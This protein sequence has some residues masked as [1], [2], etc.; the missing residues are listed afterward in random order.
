MTTPLTTLGAAYRYVAT[1]KRVIDGDTYE[2]RVDLGFKVYVEIPIRLYGWSCP[3]LSTAAGQAAALAA[4]A[5]LDG[6]A[7]VIESYKS[8]QTFAR[9]LATVWV[10][11]ESVGELLERQGVAHRGSKVG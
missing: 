6:K 9:W 8:Q 2:L 7:L 1:T 10:N 4:H 11:G 5:L 3:E